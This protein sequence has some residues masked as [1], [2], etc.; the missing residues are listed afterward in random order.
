MS[1]QRTVEKLNAMGLP[2]SDDYLYETFNVDKPENYEQ[3]KADKAAEKARQEE[4]RQ[5]LEEMTAQ[6]LNVPQNAN[7]APSGDNGTISNRLKTFFGL[8]PEGGAE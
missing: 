6:R 2:M 3:L 1:C 4:M 5:R 8:A 7:Q